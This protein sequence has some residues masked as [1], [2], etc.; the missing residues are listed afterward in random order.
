VA[1]VVAVVVLGIRNLRLLRQTGDRLRY[2]IVA[3]ALG[4][5]TAQLVRG[6]FEATGWPGTRTND[7]RTWAG[8]LVLA[9]V[10]LVTSTPSDRA[11]PVAEAVH[12]NPGR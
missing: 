2:A 10:V 5:F 11:V 7:L 9:V 3:G 4:A 12:G 6:M 8:I 1:L